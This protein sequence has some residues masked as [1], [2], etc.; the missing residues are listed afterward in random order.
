MKLA[1]F[2]VSVSL[3]EVVYC[4]YILSFH[5][6][7]WDC[8][9]S[10]CLKVVVP[11]SMLTTSW[12]KEILN[13]MLCLIKW[14]AELLQSLEGNLRWVRW[15]CEGCFNLLILKSIFFLW[16]YFPLF[17][18]FSWHSTS[19]NL[20][21]SP[22]LYDKE[23]IVCNSPLYKWIGITIFYCKGG[24]CSVPATMLVLVCWLRKGVN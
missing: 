11:E 10:S 1:I 8:Y 19:S 20:F 13:L 5:C 2:F 21:G 12:K 6:G 17:S 4:Y 15:V 7:W 22:Y 18:I 16:C 3:C 14:L 23:E 24:G 9:C